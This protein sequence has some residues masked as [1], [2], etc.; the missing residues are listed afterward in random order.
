MDGLMR[1]T[2]DEAARQAENIVET[3]R[4]ENPDAQRC[5]H[6]RPCYPFL[7]DQQIDAHII[8]IYSLQTP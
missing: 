5:T 8:A 6:P 2:E 4:K 7:L 1:S 3:F